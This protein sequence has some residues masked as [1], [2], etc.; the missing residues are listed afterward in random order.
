MAVLVIDQVSKALVTEWIGPDQTVHRQD[1]VGT[2]IAFDYVRNS[3]VAFGLLRGR[4]W[5]VSLL[6]IVVLS[7]FMVAFWR[8]LRYSRLLQIAIGLIAGGAIGN[9]IDRTRLGYVVDF[10]AVGAWPRFN[11]ADSSITIGLMLL[12]WSLMTM[13]D[14]DENALQETTERH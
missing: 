7:G 13:P 3:G 12:V 11:V 2:I 9:L 1:L 14:Q 5:L 8:S 10:M 4:Q 6:A